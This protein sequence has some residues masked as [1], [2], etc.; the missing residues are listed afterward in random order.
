MREIVRRVLACGMCAVM[1]LSAMPSVPAMASDKTERGNGTKA[2]AEAGKAATGS[3]GEKAEDT[4]WEVRPT[5]T[6]SDA[7][8]ADMERLATKSNAFRMANSLGDIWD[9]WTGKTSFEFLDGTQGDGSPERPFLIKNREQL[10]GLSELAAMGMTVQDGAGNDYAGDYSGCCFALGGNLDMQG[11]DWIPIGFYGDSTEAAG[12]ITNVF[13][14]DFDGNGYTIKNLKINRHEAFNHIGLFGAIRNASVHDLVIIPD[15]EIKGNDRVG[16]VAGYAVDS[17]IRNVTVKNAVFATSGITGGIVG[18]LSGSVVENAKC[19]NV[20]MDAQRGLEVIYAG[21]IAGAASDSR[22]ADCQVSTGSQTAARI[23]GTG[24]IGGIVGFQN[25]SDIYNTHVSGTIGG[26]HSTAVG[27]ITGRYASGKLKVARFEGT[28]GNT[29]LGSMARE[30]AFIGTREGAATNFRYID[31]VA[32]LF[33]DS[34]AKITA[35][36]CGSEIPDDNDYTYEARIGYW[37]GED[38]FYT[39]IQGGNSKNCTDRYFYEELENGILT[40]MD[41]EENDRYTIDHFAPNSVGRPVRGYLVTVNQIDTAANGQNFYDVAALEAKGASMYSKVLDKYNRGAVAA[42]SMVYVSTSPKNTETEK[43]QMAGSPYYKNAEGRKIN[44]SYVDSAHCY[45]FPM[46]EEDVSVGAVYKKVAAAIEVKPAVYHFAVRQT[47]TGDRKNPVKITEINNKEGKLIARY[48]NGELE[49]GT[50]VLPVTIQAVIDANNDVADN[51]VVWSIDDGDLIVLARNDDEEPGGYTAKSASIAVNLNA[52]FFTGI[53]QE[54]EQKQAEENYRYKIP[55]TIYGAGYQ[56]GGVAILTAA[57]RPS[58]SFEGKP[59][60]ANCRINVT[61]QIVD[62]TLI[63]A[64]GAALDKQTLEFTV[65]RT[66]TGDRTKPE[67]KILVTAPQSLTAAFT[68]DFFSREEVSWSVGDPALIGVSQDELS[69]KEALV[70]AYQD[71]KWIK[72]LIAADDGRKKNDP[73]T[74]VSGSGERQTVVTVE[75]RDRLG[76]HAT[77]DCRVTVRFVTEDE[78]VIEPVEVR[79]EPSAMDYRL[80]YE[81]AGDIKSETVKKNGFDAR[82]LKA[83]VLPELEDSKEHRP[84]DRSVVWSSSDPAA[85]SV[86]GDGNLTVIDG[87]SWIREALAEPPYQAQKTVEITAAPA[88]G[89]KAAVCEVTLQ[90]QAECIEADRETETFSIVLTKTGRRSAPIC[91]YAGHEGKAIKASI[92][93]GDHDLNRVVWASSDPALVT[94]SQEGLVTPVLFDANGKL[95]AEWIQEAMKTYPYMGKREVTVTAATTDGRMVDPVTILLDF[96]VVDQTYSSE[97]S[98]G[99]GG[100]SGSKGGAST[101]VTPGGKTTGPA[102]PAGAVTGTW[103]QAANGRWI[104]AADRTYAGEWAFISNPYAGKDQPGASWFRFDDDGFMVTGWFTDPTGFTYYLNP[105]SDGTQ[106]RMA[107]GWQFLDGNWYYFNPVSD[108]TRGRLMT[109]CVIDGL[110]YVDEKGRWVR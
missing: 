107:E 60:T 81:K 21:G 82:R 41:E 51:R 64:E 92:Y 34:A 25:S 16:A 49:Q 68:P 56:N 95:S 29:Q 9:G 18:G 59:C 85:L 10:M 40:V 32:Y 37:H 7:V 91:T 88:A 39:L 93:S 54:L 66:L 26:Y 89:G 96:R 4:E 94:V 6:G 106:G 74:S 84:F 14:G 8:G 72:D 31:D 70:S 45:A 55:N 43:F 69:Y 19:D 20:V 78:T 61:F 13:E 62:Q 98:G 5:A 48:I 11:I 27:G 100:S 3:N 33:T 77:A 58:A 65:K 47:R 36:V 44:A 80:S 97:S 83:V 53:I 71:A 1:L 15:A 50:E 17:E 109:N 12:E 67:E 101:G 90:F 104:F 79:L 102:A 86:D 99:A 42:G 110:Y 87:A 108:G 22:I 52:G 103:T 46:P 57:T 35:N 38:L 63:A 76:N 75:G 105:G 2:A 24:Y 30:G 23:Q 28:I 73:Y